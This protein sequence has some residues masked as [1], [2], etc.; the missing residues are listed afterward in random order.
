MQRSLREGK[1]GYFGSRT[2]EA[3][4]ME[5]E[6]SHAAEVCVALNLDT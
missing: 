1:G 2:G 4:S 5:R 3:D 6:I